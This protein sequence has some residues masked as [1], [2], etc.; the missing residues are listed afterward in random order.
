M[1]F[2]NG[3]DNLNEDLQS[4]SDLAINCDQ[5][6]KVHFS[7]ISVVPVLSIVVFKICEEGLENSRHFCIYICKSL[8]VC[9]A[10]FP[11]YFGYSSISVAPMETSTSSLNICKV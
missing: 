3:F 11:T 5:V 10:T 4:N 1:S 2:D 7:S 9:N 6:L 8:C